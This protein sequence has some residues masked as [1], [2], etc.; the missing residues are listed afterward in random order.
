MV[1]K[2]LYE[3]CEQE[4]LKSAENLVKE[5]NEIMDEVEYL[6]K[7]EHAWN[8]FKKHYVIFKD[9]RLSLLNYPSF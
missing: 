7:F 3:K 9:S 4:A 6:K 2:I 5:C 8:A 1:Y